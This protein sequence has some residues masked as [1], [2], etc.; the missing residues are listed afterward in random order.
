M[1][2]L[3]G[4]ITIA[5]AFILAFVLAS[6]GNASA[7]VE[8][9]KSVTA[10]TTSITFNLTF[11]DNNGNLE[12]KKAVPH[13]KLY[14]YSEEATDH[15]G[16]YLSQDKTCSFT[17]NIYTSSTVT[18]TSLTKDTKY[19]FR[20]YV[21][22]NE[23]EELLDTWVF[24]TSNDNAKEI[25]TKDDFLGMVDDPDGDYTLMNNIDFE[26]DEISGMFTSESKAF[27]GTF[28]GKGHTISNFKFSTSN[29]GLFS[30]TDGATIKNLVVVGSDED[31]LDKMRDSEGNGIEIINGDY[32]TGRSSANIGILVGT[33]TNTEFA[34]ITID[35]VNISVK[36]NSSA[37]LNVGGVVGKAVDSSFT[38]VHAT[39]V[40]LEFPYVR[41]NVCAGLF[42]GSVSGEGKA[43]DTETY[44]A[45]NTSAEGTI[46]GTL[47][48]TSSEGYAYVG[49]YAGDLGS[50]GLV[51]DSYVVA[52][53]TLYRDTT[54]T[55]LNKFALTVGG[56]AGANLNGSMN[57]LKCAAIADVLV[58]AGNS[59]TSDTDAEANK[60]STKIAYVAGFVGCVN[61]HINIIKDSCYVKKANGVNVYALEKETDDENNEKIL[62]VA[63]NVCANV[64]SATKLSNVVCANDETFDTAVLSE[65]V[66]KLVNQYLA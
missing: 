3:T 56:F 15:V 37:D 21:T 25:K 34:D 50:S 24:A 51:S 20:F 5:F 14:G 8:V 48:Y 64:Y 6:C 4:F 19:S 49:G 42:A 63:S 35:N 11:A 62:Y 58:K 30:Y 52:D 22:F 28:D 9:D 7:G 27:T 54:T 36:G 55:N 23:A 47:F 18:F 26:G 43:V 66:A 61:K 33:A 40:S 60:L 59:Q 13:I 10:T 39:N 32:S 46:T 65:N 41:L 44:T 17:N 57:V 16:D 1:K 2:K 53:I 38:N 31:Y 45:K 12:S 29:F